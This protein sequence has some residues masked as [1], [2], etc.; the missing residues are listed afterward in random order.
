M[1]L[2]GEGPTFHVRAVFG[3][4]AHAEVVGLGGLPPQKVSD[5]LVVDLQV[6]EGEQNKTNREMYQNP[7]V[8]QSQQNRF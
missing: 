5:A 1:D 2:Q 4:L 7:R 8:L 3:M 6:A